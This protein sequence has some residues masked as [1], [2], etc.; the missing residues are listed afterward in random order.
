MEHNYN[1][2][3][4]SCLCKVLCMWIR[5]GLGAIWRS[6]CSITQR[7]CNVWWKTHQTLSSLREQEKL[8]FVVFLAFL[9]R[10][11][12]LLCVAQAFGCWSSWFSSWVLGLSTCTIIPVTPGFLCQLCYLIC[13]NH[14]IPNSDVFYK[15]ADHHSLN[16]KV[17]ED[18]KT[19]VQSQIRED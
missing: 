11:T 13:R 10:D 6:L 2:D 8:M 15:V 1:Y 14:L 3:R 16:V 5:I 4:Q 9:L 17:T 19:L 12:A 18:K 7:K